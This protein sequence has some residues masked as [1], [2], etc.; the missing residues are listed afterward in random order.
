MVSMLRI[1]VRDQGREQLYTHTEGPLEFGR[2]PAHALP[3]CF[4]ID[5]FV[6]RDHARVELEA[7]GLLRVENLSRT[8]SI[9]LPNGCE[10][11]LGGVER[12]PLPAHLEFGE[13]SVEVELQPEA[14]AALPPQPPASAPAASSVPSIT[15][16]S[17]GEP[18]APGMMTV[19]RPAAISGPAAVLGDLGATP[20]PET[21]ARWFERLVLVQQ[22]AATSAEFLEATA[23]AVVDLVGLDRG[24]VLLL[25]DG[26]W[27]VGASFPP[28]AEGAAPYSRTILQ[29]ALR[30][31]RTVFR[32]L[33]DM[34]LSSSLVGID[35]VVAAPVL[36]AQQQVIG[37]VYGAREL[38]ADRP[39]PVIAPLEALVVQVLAAAVGAGLEREGLREKALRSQLQFEQFFS[40][41]LARELAGDAS[42]LTGREREV[43][44]LFSDVRNFSRISERLGARRTFTMMQD[45]MDLQSVRIRESDGVI[46]DYVG[47]GLLAMWNAPADQSD[48][49]TRACNAAV[50]I[51]AD[52][53][54]L[55]ARWLAEAGEP[56]RLGIGVHTGLALVGN[57]GSSVKFKYG[58]MG[59]A[60]N[61]ASRV[62]NATKSLGV[63]MLITGATRDRLPPGFAT[64]RL[65]GLHVQGVAEPV[66]VFELHSGEVTPAWTTMRDSFEQ[67]LAHFEGRRWSGACQI[68]A[69]LLTSEF[70]YDIPSL[71]MLSRAV[72]CLRSMP[73]PFDPAM[74]IQKQA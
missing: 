25:Q 51:A 69:G 49:A 71:Q 35:T 60:V 30:L 19:A 46:V 1:L 3:R 20:D 28:G 21:L 15:S 16:E 56:L 44:L 6:S 7:G 64:R 70:G 43:S 38:R 73:D 53:P 33:G 12:V 50:A 40:P 52:L 59:P 42:L 66:E 17:P 54:A 62:E 8:S 11:A 58:P 55:A 74:T 32:N 65:G 31:R 5:P 23:R 68:L 57:T 34:D 14:H 9:H 37:V 24:L 48:H 41:A 39:M 18:V 4:F 72:E 67:A 27:R 13:S 29:E 63:S 10:I 2:G 61:L 22:A 26:N 45:V 36:D 47:D